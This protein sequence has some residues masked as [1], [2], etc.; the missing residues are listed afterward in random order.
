M[1][2]PKA[3]E[4]LYTRYAG[5]LLTL[6]RR[7][8]GDSD[9]AKDL[10]QDALIKALENIRTYQFRGRGSL[11]AWTSR[12][13]V[14]MSINHISRIRA[15]FVSMDILLQREDVEEPDEADMLL[16]PK[17]RLMGMISSLPESRRLVFN[18]Y[19]IEGYSHREIAEMLGI[20]EKGSASLLAKARKQLK[21]MIG[22]YL[23]KH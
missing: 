20:S 10:M 12:I 9:L 22:D 11:Y 4:E 1:C 16:I 21:M 15:R 5:R 13:A 8:T 18:M 19:C 17:E 6:C 23:R 7:Y 2:D 3:E 14:N